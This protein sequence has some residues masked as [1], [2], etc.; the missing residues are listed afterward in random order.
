M[1]N[2][3]HGL[4][5]KDQL[6]HTR[7]CLVK[8]G[9]RISECLAKISDPEALKEW[10]TWVMYKLFYFAMYRFKHLVQVK[11]EEKTWRPYWDR[12]KLSG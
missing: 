7:K 3:D 9:N 10:R 11:F 6:A 12:H 4:S 1:D 8:I 5:E 2:P